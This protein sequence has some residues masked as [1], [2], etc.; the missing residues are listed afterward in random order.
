MD[1][2]LISESVYSFSTLP[3]KSVHVLKN[4]YGWRFCSHPKGSPIGTV[5]WFTKNIREPPAKTIGKVILPRPL[6]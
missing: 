3:L 5:K 1:E 4:Q 6:T 2:N